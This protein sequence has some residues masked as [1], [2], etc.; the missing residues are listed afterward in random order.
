MASASGSIEDRWGL[1]QNGDFQ[2]TF[3]V[4]KW[5]SES[6]DCCLSIVLVQLPDLLIVLEKLEF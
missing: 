1:W 3:K 5:Y 2:T 6:T 4:N